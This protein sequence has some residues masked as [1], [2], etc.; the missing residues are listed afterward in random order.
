MNARVLEHQVSR[1]LPEL[2]TFN[3]GITNTLTIIPPTTLEIRPI[4]FKSPTR[5]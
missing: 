5:I 3:D 4:T 1:P 2:S